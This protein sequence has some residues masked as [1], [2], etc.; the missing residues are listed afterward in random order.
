LLVSFSPYKTRKLKTQ[1]VKAISSQGF[2][3]NGEVSP[4]IEGKQGIRMIHQLSRKEQLIHSKTFLKTYLKKVQEFT[5]SGSDLDPEKM[6]LKL[7]EV[8]SNT[9]EETIYRWW[10]LVWWSMPYQRAYGRQ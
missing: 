4:I 6:D 8:E 7:I 10:N 1:I 5:V 2:Y 9:V 3:V